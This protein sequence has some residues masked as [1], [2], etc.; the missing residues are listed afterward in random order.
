[1]RFKEFDDP[2][3]PLIAGVKFP[4]RY[5]CCEWG[6]VKPKEKAD[7]R[8]CYCFP[9]VYEVGMSY[10]GF[11]LLY[12]RTKAMDGIDAER[13]YCPWTDMEAALR[14]AGRP[15]GS[16]ESGRALKDFDAVGFTLQ[17]EMSFTN[18]LTMLDLGGIPLLAADR[19]DSDPI[20][21]AGGPA[22]LVPEPLADFIDIFCLGDGEV[23]N[24]PLFELLKKMKGRPRAERLRAAA[25]LDG[26]YVPSLVTC[27]YDEAGVHFSSEFSLPRRRLI[28]SDMDAIAPESMIVPASGIIH[29]RV[30]V[31]LFRGCSRGCRFC[32]AGMIY[33]PVRERSLETAEQAIRRLIARTGWE[34]CS[35]VSLASCDYPQIA[36]LLQSL[37]DLHDEG[38]KVSL[39]SLRVDNF[40]VK[41][42][43]GLEVMKKGG[44]TL[45]PE[46]GSQR[47]RDVINKGVSEEQFDEALHAAFEHGW[48]KIKLY[49]MMGL[50]GE[51]DEDLQGIVSLAEHAASVGR[52]YTKRAVINVS[53]AGFVP[54]GQTPF[55]WCAQ[56]TPVELARKGAFM[57]RQIHTRAVSF[58]Y[59]EASQ[60]FIEGVLARGDRRVGRAVLEAWRLGERFDSWSETFSLDRWLQ[61]FHNTGIDPAWYAQRVR[62]D[63]ECFPWDHID[64]GVARDFLLREY[65]RAQKAQVTPDCRTGG[66]HAC[67]WQNRGCQWSGVKA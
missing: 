27:C 36:G 28:C 6:N 8:I 39:P 47:M 16:L 51:T 57:K 58:K 33:R 46:A 50:P 22:A 14:R 31:E 7:F 20:V 25:E 49:F 60:S 3:W 45:A 2:R 17:H 61:A 52:S 55:Q 41:L 29:D 67:G 15:L 9:D 65:H 48:Q 11:Q 43:A 38:I 26:T 62:P 64:T 4:S 53:V 44:L 30:A 19:G 13:A 56:N 10:L 21:M 54:K 24:P 40:S 66:C 32:Q 12:P 37:S 34:E 1:M 59:H 42:A 18:I 63:D 23:V 5:A 35:L